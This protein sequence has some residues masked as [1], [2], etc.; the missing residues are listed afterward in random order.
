MFASE[1]FQQVVQELRSKG[2]MTPEADKVAARVLADLRAAEF[3]KKLAEVYGQVGGVGAR[4][5]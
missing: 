5:S 3:H 2:L 4:N 1:R